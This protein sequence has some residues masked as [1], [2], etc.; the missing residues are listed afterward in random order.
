MWS[1]Q[2]SKLRK[3]EHGFGSNQGSR[4]AKAWESF[5][6][7][8]SVVRRSHLP[9]PRNQENKRTKDRL[10]LLLNSPCYN[11]TV[12]VSSSDRWAPSFSVPR[13][14]DAIASPCHLSSRGHDHVVETSQADHYRAPC[15]NHRITPL[16]PTSVGWYDRC[17][18]LSYKKGNPSA[19]LP[20]P[21]L[22]CFQAWHCCHSCFFS[23]PASFWATRH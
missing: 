7:Y 5:I 2:S 15:G 19:A 8:Q 11:L 6:T 4:K 22:A 13:W 23:P 9:N 18:P 21:S 16:V 20:F 12:T 1:N 17:I 3:F 10:N 14:Y